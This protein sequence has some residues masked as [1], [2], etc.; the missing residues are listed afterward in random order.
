MFE[1]KDAYALEKE[2]RRKGV[3][4]ET[5]MQEQDWGGISANIFDPDRKQ[6]HGLPAAATVVRAGQGP[7]SP[8]KPRTVVPATSTWITMAQRRRA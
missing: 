6:V 1:T 4:F 7:Q 5:K 2:L 3:K 8:S